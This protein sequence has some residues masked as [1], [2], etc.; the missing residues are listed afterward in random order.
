MKLCVGFR[1]V[2]FSCVSVAL[3]CSM[4]TPAIELQP[5]SYT[6]APAGNTVLDLTYAHLRRDAPGRDR[7]RF[8][9]NIKS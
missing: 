2:S 3:C 4:N 5:G 1:P 6:P 9:T 7:E 8:I